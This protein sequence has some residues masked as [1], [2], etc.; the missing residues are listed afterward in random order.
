[1]TIGNISTIVK[2]IVMTIAPAIGVDEATGNSIATIIVAII[3]FILSYIDA[4]YPNTLKIL[5]NEVNN[6]DNT[7]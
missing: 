5:K 6:N 2:F 7:T 3:G 4:Y 1:M